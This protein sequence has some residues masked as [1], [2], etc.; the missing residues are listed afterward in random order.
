MRRD[1]A[2]A[3][4]SPDPT[5]PPVQPP[6]ADAPPADDPPTQQPPAEDPPQKRPPMRGSVRYRSGDLQVAMALR[7]SA[8]MRLGRAPLA[9][10]T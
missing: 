1:V 5:P 6:P 7:S 3:I 9:M 4:D 8:P 10:A 2:D